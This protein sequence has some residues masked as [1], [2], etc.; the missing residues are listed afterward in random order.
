VNISGYTPNFE[1]LCRAVKSGDAAILDVFN[2]RLGRSQAALVA[3][4]FDGEE[5]TFTPLAIM[6]EDDPYEYL[7]PPKSDSTGEHEKPE[8]YDER[9][10]EERPHLP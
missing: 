10:D 1:T 4:A 6:C 8:Q 7:L 3:V 9:G 5:Y 2:K